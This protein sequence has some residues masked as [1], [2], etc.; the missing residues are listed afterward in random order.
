MSVFLGLFFLLNAVKDC[1]CFLVK[2]EKIFEIY[3]CSCLVEINLRVC[4]YM[5]KI[6]TY[7]Y[8]IY[9]LYIGGSGSFFSVFCLTNELGLV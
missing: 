4:L 6:L 3:F 1:F 8:P 7:I 5:G 2:F 9:R